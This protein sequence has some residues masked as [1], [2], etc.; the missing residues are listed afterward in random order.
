MPSSDFRESCMSGV[1][2]YA[3]PDRTGVLD[4]HPADFPDLPVSVH[5]A[6]GHALVL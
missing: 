6:C 2:P 1:R 5:G 3:C 4:K